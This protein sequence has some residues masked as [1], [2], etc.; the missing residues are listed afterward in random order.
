MTAL[1]GPGKDYKHGFDAACLP[2][3]GT[4]IWDSF[5]IGIFQWIP[6]KDG[7]RLKRGKVKVRVKGLISQED[8]MR[9]LAKSFAAQLDAGVYDG[10]KLVDI[11]KWRA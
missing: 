6:N 11:R 7:S 9:S 1:S 3:A 2:S 8:T 4:C 10:P 5:S